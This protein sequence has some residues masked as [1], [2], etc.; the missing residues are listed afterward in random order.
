MWFSMR[1]EEP[2]RT[3]LSG[4][5]RANRSMSFSGRA[6]LLCAGASLL[7]QTHD[8][9]SEI[10]IG[11]V[12]YT[13]IA[14]HTFTAE[15]R[16]V[17][18]PVVVRDAHDR[19]VAGLTK[20][21]FAVFDSGK[22]RTITSFSAVDAG[23]SPPGSAQPERPRRFMAL[24]IDD[25]FVI[26][27]D[28][29][30]A[31]V[32]VDLSRFFA[33]VTQMRTPAEGLFKESLR[34]GDQIS[35]FG[36]REGQILPFQSDAAAFHQALGHITTQSI[37][38]DVDI[39]LR[40]LEDIVNY[41]APLPGERSI[42]LA[43]RLIV[44]HASTIKRVIAR[45]LKYGITI[46]SLDAGGVGTGFSPSG[47]ADD[48][49]FDV[50]YELA[51]GTGGTYFHNNNDFTRGMQ[52]L[53]KVPLGSYLLGIVPDDA[54]DGRYHALKVKTAAGTRYSVKAR[55]GYYAEDPK[56][57]KP[58]PETRLAEI[59]SGSESRQEVPVTFAVAPPKPEDPPQVLTVVL[60]IDV[61]HLP[62]YKENGRRHQMLTMV[63]ALD[64]DQGNFVTGGKGSIVF[65]LKEAAHAEMV[66][67][68]KPVALEMK[69]GAPP[70]RYRL[71][72]VL[73][74]DSTNRITAAS[75]T[76]ELKAA[77]QAGEVR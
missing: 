30:G 61:P 64:D 59:V 70:G 66:K 75:Q 69:L 9:S 46:D 41:L 23:V 36:F 3:R 37:C 35:L 54:Q 32:S 68:A 71:R 33:A 60:S 50:L 52:E 77:P 47:K 72:T 57:A 14:A 62:F 45:A 15:T 22:P 76:I 38:A 11:A 12:P 2:C 18:I 17:E 40:T 19:P 44:G 26:P 5:R 43:S 16:L 65:D 24:V 27:A 13:P 58:S 74:E 63:A 28:G 73:R 29:C 10:R 1:N 31:R 25:L 48:I 49:R 67:R 8:S 53:G 51:D 7:A 34:F 39:K 4:N 55:P 56:N 21:D 20:A 6:L 42:L